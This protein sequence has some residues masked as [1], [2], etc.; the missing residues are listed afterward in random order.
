[1]LC[2][3]WLEPSVPPSPSE[4]SLLLIQRLYVYD[5][6]NCRPSEKRLLPEKNIALYSDRASTSLPPGQR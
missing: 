4:A 6:P 2:G 5:P 3:R 1:M